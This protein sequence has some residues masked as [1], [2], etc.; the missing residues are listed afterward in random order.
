MEASAMTRAPFF[1]LPLLLIFLPASARAAGGTA[2][3]SSGLALSALVAAN[4]PTLAASDKA[5][6]AAL[7]NAQPGVSY[8]AGRKIVIAA[9]AITCSA[10][11]VDITRH[12]CV[13]QFGSNKITLSGRMAHE[14]FAT[15][16]EVG[17]APEG[18][19]G[20]L[21]ESLTH[22]SCSVDPNEIEQ[23]TGGGVSCSFDAGS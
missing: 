17:V 8:P 16:I 13:L 9:D 15:L 20:T 12:S 14:I 11:D 1:A 10:G 7:F 4:S 22:L 21:Y 18:A 3:G 6:M 19:A 2:S 5:V 23:N